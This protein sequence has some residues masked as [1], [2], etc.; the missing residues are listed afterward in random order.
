METP[1]WR[2]L[3]RVPSHAMACTDAFSACTITP[4]DITTA[5]GFCAAGATYDRHRD[6]SDRLKGLSTQNVNPHARVARVTV[7]TGIQ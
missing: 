6:P 5:S 4:L 7:P 1:A 2:H 3:H